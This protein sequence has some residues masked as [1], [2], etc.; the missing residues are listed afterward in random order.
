MGFILGFGEMLGVTGKLG[1]ALG[2]LLLLLLVAGGSFGLKSCYDNSVVERAVT[3]GN[4]KA[5]VKKGKADDA[6]SKARVADTVRATEEKE[7]LN[8]T[9]NE[10]VAAGRDPRDDYYDCVELQQAARRSQ[11]ATPDC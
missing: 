11:S 5:L 3:S 1:K 2:P 4:N 6:A 7:E 10:A 8:D 9:I